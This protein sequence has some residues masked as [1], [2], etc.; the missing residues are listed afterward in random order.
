MT[1]FVPRVVDPIV[2]F[3]VKFVAGIGAEG[4]NVDDRYCNGKVDV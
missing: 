2:G 3:E 4:E 1:K